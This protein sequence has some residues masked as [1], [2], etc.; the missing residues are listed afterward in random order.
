MHLCTLV[1]TYSYISLYIHIPLYHL[2]IISFM[3]FYHDLAIHVLSLFLSCMLLLIHVFLSCSIY[4][5]MYDNHIF[6]SYTLIFISCHL[7]ITSYILL[8]YIFMYFIRLSYL[9]LFLPCIPINYNQAISTLG[10]TIQFSDKMWAPNAI[11]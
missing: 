2:Y 7:L 1:F 6:I 8:T 4:S 10:I 3:R 11:K 5:F 9:H